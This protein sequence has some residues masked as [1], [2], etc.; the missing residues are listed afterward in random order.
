MLQH[1]MM[2]TQ[3]PIENKKIRKPVKKIFNYIPMVFETPKK[4]KKFGGLGSTKNGEIKKDMQRTNGTF[5]SFKTFSEVVKRANY[6][7]SCCMS[8]YELHEACRDGNLAKVEAYIK[9]NSN[10][11]FGIN[12]KDDRGQSPLHISADAN[13]FHNAETDHIE[14]TREKVKPYVAIVKVLLEAGAN[15]NQLNRNGSPPLE[16]ACC[17]G[18]DEIVVALCEGGADVNLMSVRDFGGGMTPLCMACR[19]A[20]F[21]CIK[22]LVERFGADVNKPVRILPYDPSPLTPS[23]LLLTHLPIISLIHL[24]QCASG[25]TPLQYAEQTYDE[26]LYLQIH[27]LLISK[28]AVDPN[29]RMKSCYLC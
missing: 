4:K 28:G 27:N 7:D 18:V 9:A 12:K 1:G 6:L 20:Q 10:H 5:T 16:L 2:D 24:L 13:I 14:E 3:Q 17:N 29:R 15:P 21:H 22:A 19:H 11:P 8:I 26:D 23:I 25:R